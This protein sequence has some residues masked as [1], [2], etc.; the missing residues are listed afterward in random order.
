MCGTKSLF[1]HSLIN[2]GHDKS[3]CTHLNLH[4]HLLSLIIGD[5][6]KQNKKQVPVVVCLIKNDVLYYHIL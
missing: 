6:K 5:T 4:L 2:L 1:C 3:I